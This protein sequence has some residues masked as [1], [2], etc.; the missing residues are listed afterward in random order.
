MRQFAVAGTLVF[1]NFLAGCPSGETSGSDAGG[2]GQGGD[3][4]SGAGDVGGT[5]GSS[6]AAADGGKA[7]AGGSNAGSAGRSGADA[8]GASGTAGGGRGGGSG[9]ASN[10]GRGGAG[11]GSGTGGASGA[12]APAGSTMIVGVGS[13]AF[14]GRSSDG[15]SWM[16]CGESSGGDD[17]APNLLRNIA[18]G[19]GVFIAVGGDA[20]SMVM[21]SLDGVHWQNDLHGTSSCPGESYPQSCKN[22][23][24]AVAFHAGVWVAA[25]GN[26]AVMRSTDGGV[27]WTGL[28]STF[29]EARIRAIGAGSGRFLAGTDGGAIWLSTDDGAHWM[30]KTPW[31]NASSDAFLQFAH[32]A[33]TFIAF[34]S[35]F[36]DASA[37][38]CFVSS[39]AGDDWEPCAASVKSNLSFVHDGS[40]WVT[41]ASGGYATSSD[42]KTWMTHTASNVPSILL[43]DGTAWYGR[44]GGSVYRGTTPD[45][46]ARVAMGVSEFR[47]WAIG[48]VL[49][50]NL[51]VTGVPA[52]VDNR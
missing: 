21:R 29:S 35:D 9:D 37:R 52:C 20:N 32:G 16:Y 19:D 40:R 3:T 6:G 13:A 18:Y 49:D 42:G 25:G 28:P 14:R 48:K 17:H 1:C 47:G 7:G 5:G 34:A 15:A 46:F 44:S 22:W 27:S 41:P 2:G 50:E 38:A 24:G 10:A 11:N 45:D 33:G 23:M 31:A 8:R 26:G 30:K 4:G 43:F 51:P 36:V 39:N 12:P